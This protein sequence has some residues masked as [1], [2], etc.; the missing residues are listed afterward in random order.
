MAR[1]KTAGRYTP[2]RPGRRGGDETSRWLGTYGDAV[3]LLLAFFVILYAMSQIDE[4]KFEAFVSGL[5]IPFGNPAVREGLLDASTA[6]VG[7]AAESRFPPEVRPGPEVLVEPPG[8]GEQD[9]EDGHQESPEPAPASAPLSPIDLEQLHRV[10]DEVDASLVQ[11]EL[12]QH[13]TYRFDERGV[14]VS[15][16]ADDVLF[17]TGS[18]AISPLGRRVVAAVAR[19]L[20]G[21]P[22]D[23]LV[24][25]HTDDVPLNRS[26]Y[27][28][29]NLSTDRAVAVVNL[30][31]GD[32][33]IGQHR[34]GAVGYGQFRPIAPNDTARNRALN[35][36]VDVLVV[37]K[38]V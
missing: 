38:G 5:E 36:R 4:V 17:D 21:F 14:V 10:R 12:D 19:P 8:G 35:R 33:G 15:I 34:L 29:W 37:A 23:V 28:N 6:V 18:T 22:N 9:D 31:A 25:G 11:A 27:T 3:T 7:D 16:A 30:L 32:F 26:G 20:R 13:A 1:G 2:E 24:E